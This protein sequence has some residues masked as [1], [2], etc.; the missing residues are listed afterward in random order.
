MLARLLLVALLAVSCSARADTT[1]QTIVHML[2]YMS[3]DYPEFVK[4]GKV[5]DEAEYKEQQEFSGQVTVLL[6][7]L[8]EVAQRAELLK[9]AETLKA[10]IDA[11]APGAEVS[12]LASS[13]RWR[14]I[15]AYK[16]TVAPKSIPD[17]KRGAALYAAAAMD[18]PPKA[19]IRCPRISTTAI[20]WR[21]AAS[22][23]STAPSRS[24]SR[25]PR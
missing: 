8:P 3:V 23:G 13:L 16:L 20:A 5:L 11:K 14:V 7:K 10:R 1:A 21:S 6:G 9:Q 17:L 19:S 18:P 24:A 2:D 12:K 15:E 4:D 25:A 22:M